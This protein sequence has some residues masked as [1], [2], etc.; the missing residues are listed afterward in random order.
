MSRFCLLPLALL[1]A[2]MP[3]AVLGQEEKE[4][5]TFEKE[6]GVLVRAKA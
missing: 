5:I 3:F 1:L 6:N 4:V 2:A